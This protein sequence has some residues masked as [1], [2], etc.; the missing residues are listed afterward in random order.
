MYLVKAKYFNVM[1]A[2]CAILLTIAWS[3]SKAQLQCAAGSECT[4]INNIPNEIIGDNDVYTTCTQDNQCQTSTAMCKQ[5]DEVIPKV[6]CNA[7]APNGAVYA[8]CKNPICEITGGQAGNS[9][10]FCKCDHWNRPNGGCVAVSE[11]RIFKPMNENSQY[12][13][14]GFAFVYLIILASF[15]GLIIFAWLINNCKNQ[16]DRVLNHDWFKHNVFFLFKDF[17]D[18]WVKVFTKKDQSGAIELTN[19]SDDLNS[20]PKRLRGL[21]LHDLKQTTTV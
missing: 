16:H 6:P 11:A 18:A 14:A 1:R 8:W 21:K 13:M 20:Q 7:R 12:H 17:I 15:Y 3:Q 5:S 19:L 2:T 4:P 9:T 10:G